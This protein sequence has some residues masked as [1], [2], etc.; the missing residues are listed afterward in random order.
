MLCKKYHQRVYDY[1]SKAEITKKDVVTSDLPQQ[2][3]CVFYHE[4]LAL[5]EP[6]S[7]DHT[8]HCRVKIS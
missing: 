3:S 2:Q 1:W 6:Y 4:Y 5:I 8:L 7:I